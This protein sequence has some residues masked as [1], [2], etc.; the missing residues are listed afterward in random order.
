M[1]VVT[2]SSI[3]YL[4]GRF[5][6]LERTSVPVQDRGFLF[7]DGVYEVV[8][9][10]QGRPFQLA[11]HLKRLRKSLRAV[12]IDDPMS[13]IQWVQVIRDLVEQNGDG[14]LSVYIQITRGI[15]NREHE[16]P[17]EM[18]PT[19]F[20]MPQ[21]LPKDSA[22]DRQ[23]GVSAMTTE[24]IRWQRCDIKTISLMANVML[25]QM[26]A[27]QGA[28]EMILLRDGYVTEGAASS[29][30]VVLA[31][32]VL[33]PTLS[34]SILPGITRKVVMD[35][36]RKQ[37]VP[38]REAAI[39]LKSLQQADEVWLVGSTRGISPVTILD[40]R[41]VKDGEPGRV[42]QQLDQKYRMRTGQRARRYN[43]QHELP[44]DNASVEVN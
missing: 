37:G 26:A 3:A 13:E 33:T 36:C 31:G 29:V 12:G 43:G 25:K 2:D 32:E 10:Y 5:Q 11:A 14:D 6:L 23:A 16:Y 20:M 22:N 7:G 30:F 40:G 34:G 15:T 19:V 21:P 39:S 28:D 27:E 9:V 41:P 24:D 1:P 8:P 4:N 42:W 38:F 18:V 17:P 44:L 35:L